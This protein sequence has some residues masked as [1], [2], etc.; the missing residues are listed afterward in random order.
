M[1]N[2]FKANNI[3][4][5]VF[6][7][8]NKS[9]GAYA[10]RKQYDANVTRAVLIMLGSFI[11]L[12][13]I[14]IFIPNPIPATPHVIP[15]TDPVKLDDLVFDLP[16]VIPQQG[17]SSPVVNTSTDNGN[18]RIEI[19]RKVTRAVAPLPVSPVI[20]PLTSSGTPGGG[21]LRS[22]LLPGTLPV[23]TKPETPQTFTRAEFMPLF[24]NGNSDLYEYLNKEIVYPQR[25]ISAG[26]SGKVIVS[27]DI[28]TE[29]N[30]NNIHV[31]KGI[32]FGCDEEAV[33]VVKNMPKWKPAVQNGNKVAI[34]MSL[35][36]MFE[37]EN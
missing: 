1:L 6:A 31:L 15:N 4:E 13:F 30:V 29:G 14:G 18:Y 35:P 24:D 19:D 7:N 16:V 36:I 10:I 32:G 5:V 23:Y 34:R 28:D 33:R 27:F 37:T 8:R 17:T 22:G 20:N 26:V 2:P 3:D 11:V 25:A 9:Y 12:F 21:L